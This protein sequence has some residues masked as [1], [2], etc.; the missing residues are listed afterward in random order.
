MKKNI[1]FIYNKSYIDAKSRHIHSHWAVDCKEDYNIMLWGKGFTKDKYLNLKHLNMVIQDFKPDYIYMT[2]RKKYFHKINKKKFVLW[3]P[4]LTSIKIPK[5]FVEVDTFRYSP[6]DLWYNQFDKLYC[7]CSDWGDWRYVPM[8]KWSVSEVSFPVIQKP[9]KGI[10]FIGT[11]D[12]PSYF[13]RRKL[14]SMFD[15]KITFRTI[16]TDEYWEALH[17]ASA[18]LCPSE[19]KIK[20]DTDHFIPAKLFEYL[21]SGA[22]V[23]TNCDMK[24]AGIP[25]LE[26]FVIKYNDEKDLES[27]LSM[28][29]SYCHNKAIPEMR[30][31]T[32][33]VRYK[34][35]FG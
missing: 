12:H 16:K 13:Y 26:D 7:R 28:D 29:F 33:R 1:L 24:Q 31:H 20:K 5:I 11:I 2:G 21:A 32:H 15:K 23:L 35:L 25:E 14:R 34:E 27:K 9:R 22:A 4:D 8:L 3:L 17:S 19:G 18:L 30:K 6:S 10:Y